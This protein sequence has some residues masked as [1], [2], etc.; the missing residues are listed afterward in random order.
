MINNLA[1]FNRM[2]NWQP[3]DQLMTYDLIDNAEILVRHGGYDFNR[4]YSFDELIEVNARAFKSIGLNATRGIYDPVNHW[5]GGK[6][7]N[8]IRFFGVGEKDWEVSQAGGTA[9][10]SRRPFSN[11]KELE[12]N[13]PQM[14]KFEDV[15]QWYE[16]ILKK[17]KEVFDAYDLVYVG[18]VEGP[19]SDAYTY[20]D[21]ELFMM[22]VYDAPELVAHI[23]DCT[24]EF[25]ACIARVFAQ[26]PSSSLF[27]MGEDVAGVTGPFISPAFLREH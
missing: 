27:F 9:W 23:L 6:I 21:M 13:L 25:S 4:N 22:A 8:W 14:P 10:I 11:L 7:R 15:R 20:T 3:T 19:I 12:K 5:M 2:V 1:K 24:A 18:A 17:I 16:P 26:N